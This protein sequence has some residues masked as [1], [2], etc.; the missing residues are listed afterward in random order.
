MQSEIFSKI[1]TVE[2]IDKVSDELDILLASLYKEKGRGLESALK[3]NVRAWF[4]EMLKNEITN[5]NI[6][7]EKYLRQ[8]KKE[9]AQ[10]TEVT[11]I[12]AYEPSLSSMERFQ[13]VLKSYIGKNVALDISYMPNLLAGAVIIYKG[14][15]IDLSLK[16]A[17]EEELQKNREEIMNLLVDESENNNQKS[18]EIQIT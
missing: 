10:Y 12:L 7:V 18:N 14:R 2:D 17:F 5:N 8:M 13:S 16:R 15:Y 6:G 1:I 9:L 11:L 4:S 3:Y